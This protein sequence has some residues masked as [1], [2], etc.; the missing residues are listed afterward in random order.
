MKK[1]TNVGR[2]GGFFVQLRHNFIYYLLTFLC[3][4]C[5]LSVL[6]GPKWSLNCFQINATKCNKKSSRLFIYR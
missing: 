3:K 4:T 1:E 2:I 5:T 6:S